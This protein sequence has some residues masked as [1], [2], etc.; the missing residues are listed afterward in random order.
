[1]IHMKRELTRILAYCL[2]KKWNFWL[3]DWL[4]CHRFIGINSSH[5]VKLQLVLISRGSCSFQRADCSCWSKEK[6]SSFD[7]WRSSWNTCNWIAAGMNELYYARSQC[8]VHIQ[9]KMISYMVF[10]CCEKPDW[11]TI[12]VSLISALTGSSAVDP[13]PYCW[14]LTLFIVSPSS[15]REPLA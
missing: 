8:K 13:P 14:P 15:Q 11:K 4:F 7:I 9:K 10:L 1:M 2:I 6:L 12:F 5:F 3:I